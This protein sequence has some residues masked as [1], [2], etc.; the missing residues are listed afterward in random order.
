[1]KR[2]VEEKI[3][4]FGSNIIRMDTGDEFEDIKSQFRRRILLYVMKNK[5]VGIIIIIIIHKMFLV[6]REIW[7]FID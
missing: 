2:T 7:R 4:P 5:V 1:M 6:R 3:R